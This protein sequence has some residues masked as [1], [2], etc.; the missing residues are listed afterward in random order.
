VTV[1]VS[2]VPLEPAWR[3]RSPR[4]SLG[5]LYLKLLG[6]VL[7]GYA[8]GGRGFAHLEIGGIYVGEVT[9]FL[10]VAVL[11]ATRAVL[12]IPLLPATLWLIALMAW[13]AARAARDFPEYGIDAARDA[14]LLGYACFALITAGLLASRPQRLLGLLHGYRSFARSF[15]AVIPIVC[16]VLAF[17]GALPQLAQSEVVLMQTK[18]GDVLV[19]LAGIGSAQLL[20]LLPV[21]LPSLLGFA[22]SFA[23]AAAKTRGGALAFALAL[24]SVA[25]ARPLHRRLWL[26]LCAGLSA[27]LFGLLL[28]IDTGLA[29]GKR[30]LSADQILTN[31]HSIFADSGT[32]HLD[33]TRRW[34]L[35]WWSEILDYTV[36]GSEL[37]TGRGFGPNLALIDGFAQGDGER[38]LR[39]PHNASLTVLARAGV[40]ALVLWLALHLSW[41]RML[42]NSYRSSRRSGEVR[43]AQLFLALIAY[44]TAFHVNASFDVFLEGPMGGIW[45]WTVFG[46]GLGAT[47]IYRRHPQVLRA[48]EGHGTAPRGSLPLALRGSGVLSLG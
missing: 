22:F 11:F 28:G 26:T 21:S 12:R 6:F 31:L 40:P 8:L 41:F 34:R 16:A 9:L 33:G 32:S 30:E 19:H 1:A 13:C 42:L 3:T 44:G 45:F 2:P 24:A 18:C 20:G 46:V 35:Q 37:W 23:V 38:V 15:L 36:F 39:S 10:G 5:D 4:T 43:W 25:L 29:I 48:A 7:L 17:P 27:L 14:A 47:R